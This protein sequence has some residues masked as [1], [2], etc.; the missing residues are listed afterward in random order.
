MKT[1]ELVFKDKRSFTVTVEDTQTYVDAQKKAIDMGF[2]DKFDLFDF[3]Y[4]AEVGNI[5]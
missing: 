4:W 2:F 3:D 1:I 5:I